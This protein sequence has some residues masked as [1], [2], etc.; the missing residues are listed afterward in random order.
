MWLLFM[1]DLLEISS[2]S[3][4][5][6]ND[7][8]TQVCWLHILQV[9]GPFQYI[10][11]IWWIGPFQWE[12]KCQR[13]VFWTYSCKRNWLKSHYDLEL[14]PPAINTRSH[15]FWE[16]FGKWSKEQE[17]WKE[18]PTCVMTNLRYRPLTVMSHHVLYHDFDYRLLTWALPW[19]VS[20]ILCTV[21]LEAARIA[22]ALLDCV[23]SLYPH[24]IPALLWHQL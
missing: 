7:S 24:F 23:A 15:Y 2:K 9:N 10:P 14:W 22:S 8:S 21:I 12:W 17:Y 18:T 4:W 6:W 20:V 13:E 11:P 19:W 1:I 16:K 3:F 5:S